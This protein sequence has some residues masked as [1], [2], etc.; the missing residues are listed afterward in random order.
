MWLPTGESIKATPTVTNVHQPG[1]TYYNKP[2]PPNAANPWPKN[3]QAITPLMKVSFKVEWLY[4]S[5][6]IINYKDFF[7]DL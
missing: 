4:M 3:I 2:S 1:H 6:K 7:Y 5:L